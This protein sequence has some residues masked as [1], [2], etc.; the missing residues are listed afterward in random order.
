MTELPKKNGVEVDE[1]KTSTEPE[2]KSPWEILRKHMQGKNISPVF[3][4]IFMGSK[5]DKLT[6]GER[7]ELWRNIQRLAHVAIP[8]TRTSVAEAAQTGQSEAE[9][10]YGLKFFQEVIQN[11]SQLFNAF[12]SLG[13]VGGL[14]RNS[15]NNP[16]PG[17]SVAKAMGMSEDNLHKLMQVIFGH[18]QG[19]P[20]AQKDIVAY[21]TRP[22]WTQYQIL[23]SDVLGL[24]EDSTSEEIRAQCE[25]FRRVIDRFDDLLGYPNHLKVNRVIIE[26]NRNND[27]NLST[28]DIVKKHGFVAGGGQCF[29]ESVIA[30]L[31]DEIKNPAKAKRAPVASAPAQPKSAVTAKPE[32]NFES[33]YVEVYQTSATSRIYNMLHNL[34]FALRRTDEQ[35][36]AKNK[37]AHFNNDDRDTVIG[38]LDEK[39]GADLRAA[40]QTAAQ[41][42]NEAPYQHY[43]LMEVI[44]KHA[45]C[46]S[47]P[48]KL[49][50]ELKRIGAILDSLYP[51]LGN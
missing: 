40:M 27:P 47:D 22:K 2:E 24:K 33:F 8:K 1:P 48:E 38:N 30:A 35:Y 51:K 36:K 18:L 11:D 6:A 45:D 25:K 3:H 9:K 12:Q 20:V 44:A 23:Y 37:A 26:A 50:T 31:E 13:M 43:A 19:R 4:E 39:L 29:D 46:A 34:H 16:R 10:A 32:I 41:K 15:Y 21:L 49:K 14:L 7:A 17:E 42:S 5:P 28:E